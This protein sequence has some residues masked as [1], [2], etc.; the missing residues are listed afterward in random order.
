M[1]LFS[2]FTAVVT[3]S[4]LQTQF[5]K[6]RLS[7][8]L[9]IALLLT[10]IL[11]LSGFNV[12][13]TTKVNL[14]VQKDRQISA[15][16]KRPTILL[17]EEFLAE[18]ELVRQNILE[19]VGQRVLV[20]QSLIFV[21]LMTLSWFSLYFLLKPLSD[22]QVLK[23]K[24]LAQASHELRTP[25]AI[26]YSELSLNK[27]SKNLSELK[28]VHQEAIIE[29][30]RLQNLSDT[31]LS[32]LDDQQQ[33]EEQ[34]QLKPSQIVD[35]IISK[36]EAIDD[37]NLSFENKIPAK[38]A[39]TTQ[40]NKFYQLW[41]NLLDNALKYS[42]AKGLVSIDF[43]LDQKKFSLVNPTEVV[44]IKPGVGLQICEDL[45]Q[46]LGFELRYEVVDGKCRVEIKTVS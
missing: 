32:Q 39:L 41:F 29:I 3:G 16:S 4:K 1:T 30:K 17:G 18:Q 38:F 23:E 27:N 11:V 8:S 35:Q 6:T 14:Q 19:E 7:I 25:L 15:M 26:L 12:Y 43:D 20:G 42:S 46:Q 34:T 31:L 37:K 21:Y 28:Q 45:S 40:A 33:N 44:Q 2:Q 5:R 22:S 13:L 10:P 24:F 9:L 36:L